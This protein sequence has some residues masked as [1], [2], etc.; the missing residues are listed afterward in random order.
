MNPIRKKRIEKELLKLISN[1][2]EFK[3]RDKRLSLVS[4][5]DIKITD[6]L[7]YANIYYRQLPP[8]NHKETEKAFAGAS[9]FIKNEIAKAKILRTIP[10]LRFFYDDTEDKAE[11]I[12][13]ILK[14][15]HK[16]K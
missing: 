16:E 6:D 12:E 8:R 7:S 14:K 15:I 11:K 4:I 13:E 2:I 5:V 1:T 3:M 9:G 10:E